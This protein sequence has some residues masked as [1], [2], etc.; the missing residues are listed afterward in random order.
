MSRN[1]IMNEQQTLRYLAR[2][3]AR[4]APLQ[5]STIA[6][7]KARAT[8]A[9]TE[10]KSRWPTTPKQRVTWRGQG[11][12][13]DKAAREKLLRENAERQAELRADIEARR[14]RRL[15]DDPP[16]PPEVL[17]AGELQ[18][19][20]EYERQ[21]P[22]LD[23]DTM[24]LWDAWVD[25]RI[26]AHLEEY[27]NQICDDNAANDASV[28]RTITKLRE[29]MRKEMAAWIRAKDREF[30]A[31]VSVMRAAMIRQASDDL[32]A[33]RADLLKIL[34]KDIATEIVKMKK[35]FHVKS[36]VTDIGTK[37]KI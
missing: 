19:L 23:P 4:N 15:D 25:A 18:V 11:D 32:S 24:A 13:M 17:N 34:R 12:L 33:M 7:A 37:R 3:E 36:N 30:A 28:A 29:D 14:Q 20:R 16:Q 2:R 5:K 27:H 21:R 22:V 10:P 35:S 9:R 1:K 8:L 31:E 6:I 26:T